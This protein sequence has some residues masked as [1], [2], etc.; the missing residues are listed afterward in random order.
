MRD[1]NY[2]KDMVRR[3]V[4]ITF[5]LTY[6]GRYQRLNR[7]LGKLNAEDM[8]VASI[9]CWLRGSVACKH[10]M[11][12]WRKFRDAAWAVLD[13]RNEDP[14]TVLRGM[15]PE[16][17]ADDGAWHAHLLVGRVMAANRPKQST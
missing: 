10:L 16:K 5:H 3:I 17:D 1:G 9:S 14:T 4:R 15:E 13:R 8:D 6:G 12:N 2:D 7:I 11:P